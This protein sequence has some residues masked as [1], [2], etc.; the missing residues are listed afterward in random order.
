MSFFF[1]FSWY[2]L[3]E[4]IWWEKVIGDGWLPFLPWN[5]A[6]TLK[7]QISVKGCHM[8]QAAVYLLYYVGE[9]LTYT[10]EYHSV[11][12]TTKF[13]HTVSFTFKSYML[14]WVS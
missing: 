9:L 8:P 1:F 12:L 14:Q 6:G 7:R 11:I 3:K 10:N 2:I 13:M 5:F 4:E